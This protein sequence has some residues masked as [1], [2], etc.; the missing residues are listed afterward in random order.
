MRVAAAS[1]SASASPSPSA[2]VLSS[3]SWAAGRASRRRRRQQQLHSRAQLA[4]KQQASATSSTALL[5]REGELLNSRSNHSSFLVEDDDDDDGQHQEARTSSSSGRSSW[6]RGVSMPDDVRAKISAS[7]TA[8]WQDPDF[9]ERV[10]DSLRGGTAWNLGREMSP[11]MCEKVRAARTGATASPETRARMSAA[12]RGR[13][14]SDDFREKMRR[15]KL[16]KQMTEEHKQKIAAAQR[17]RWVRKHV[18]DITP[19]SPNSSNHERRE[20]ESSNGDTREDNVDRCIPKREYNANSAG[21]SGTTNITADDG[22]IPSLARSFMM[23]ALDAFVSSGIEAERRLLNALSYPSSIG[24]NRGVGADKKLS[25]EDKTEEKEEEEEVEKAEG[26]VDENLMSEG[27]EDTA[28]A[29]RRPL[30]PALDDEASCTY[31]SGTATGRRRSIEVRSKISRAMQGRRHSEETKAKIA[32]SMRIRRQSHAAERLEVLKMHAARPL[33]S[34]AEQVLRYKQ[35]LR[36]YSVLRNELGTWS[37][38]FRKQHARRPTM[39]DVE[40]TSIPWLVSKFKQ[41]IMLRDVIFKDTAGI[42]SKLQPTDGHTGMG[43]GYA[44]RTHTGLS[45]KSTQMAPQRH[46]SASQAYTA[47]YSALASTDINQARSSALGNRWNYWDMPASSAATAK[48]AA[49]Q[50]DDKAYYAQLLA[51][52]QALGIVVLAEDEDFPTVPSETQT[53]SLPQTQDQSETQAQSHHAVAASAAAKRFPESLLAEGLE[54]SPA[55]AGPGPTVGAGYGNSQV[56]KLRNITHQLR[57]D[58]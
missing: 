35:D 53:Q 31:D 20:A 46:L 7:L 22:D 28:F 49:V 13:T 10:R 45:P 36:R 9:A 50:S 58:L 55:G 42:R 19:R 21:T 38:A 37:D 47:R 29:S 11:D 8:K 51:K 56:L 40:R 1:T 30:P 26:L 23:K 27:N 25:A 6:N 43:A 16:G 48:E 57:E 2:L 33:M 32:A 12:Q 34:N 4:Y 41:Y 5:D 14:V 54:V 15:L 39:R 52:A 17:M 18:H 3:P 24:R 44:N